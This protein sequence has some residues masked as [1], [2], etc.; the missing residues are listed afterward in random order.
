MG[1]DDDGGGIHSMHAWY[2][3]CSFFQ[4]NM[5]TSFT[6]RAIN[7]QDPLRTMFS[8]SMKFTKLS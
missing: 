3:L 8:R 1:E 2:S 7:S 5:P 6:A 4:S